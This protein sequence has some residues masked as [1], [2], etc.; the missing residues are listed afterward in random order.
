[1]EEPNNP[2]WL[3]ELAQCCDALIRTGDALLKRYRIPK[4][5]PRSVTAEYFL[6]AAQQVHTLLPLLGEEGLVLLHMEAALEERMTLLRSR[7]VP[8]C[9]LRN[10]LRRQYS[11]LLQQLAVVSGQQAQWGPPDVLVGTLRRPGQLDVCLIHGFYHVPVCQIPQERLPIRYVA[12][13][14]SRSLFPEDCGIRFYGRVKRCTVVPRWQIEE[15]PKASEELY[16]RLEIERWEQLEQPIRV[17]EIPF[18]HLFTN[19]FLLKHSRETPELDLRSAEEYRCF[20]A[21]RMAI[22][23]NRGVVLMRPQGVVRLRR[24]RFWVRCHRKKVASFSVQD[25]QRTPAAVFRRIMA[26]LNPSEN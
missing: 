23:W 14:Q 18:T 13:Y 2:V 11:E 12:I 9:P 26:V 4:R 1:M 16:Y 19:L 17:R 6:Q 8:P 21:L 5:T 24:G 22:G 7:W 20:H 3:T 15:I 10:R 25:F